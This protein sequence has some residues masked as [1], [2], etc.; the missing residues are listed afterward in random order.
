MA[1]IN[2][3]T[4]EDLRNLLTYDPETGVLTW[5]T[6]SAES[7]GPNRAEYRCKC[8]NT[9]YA[10]KEAFKAT[11]SNGYRSG[12]VKGRSESAHRVIW[13]ICHGKWPKDSIDHI[14]GDRQD[15]RLSNLRTVDTRANNMNKGLL[16]ANTSGV[17]G[18]FWDKSRRK[19]I[20]RVTVN[21]RTIPCGRF[22]DFDEAVAAREV[23]AKLHGFHP[24]H[25]KR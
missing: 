24:N 21:Y 12:V 11:N 6:R 1:K 8:W 17:A 2:L 5:K 7:F 15:N 20:A 3:P 18:V 16:S 14:N 22:D 13:A 25:G 19:W 9:R 4:P 23:A 10:G